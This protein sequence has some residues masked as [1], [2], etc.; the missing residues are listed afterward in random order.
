MRDRSEPIARSA[1]SP[2]DIGPVHWIV[3]LG[4]GGPRCEPGG[5]FKALRRRRAC[6]GVLLIRFADSSSIACRNDADSG[7]SCFNSV[8]SDSL[9]T[10]RNDSDS[11]SGR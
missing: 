4:D 3:F 10:P 11:W 5:Q 1:R 7:A 8:L 9:M 2:G 6:D